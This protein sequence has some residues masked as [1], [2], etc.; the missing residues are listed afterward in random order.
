VSH[1]QRAF[2]TLHVKSIADDGDQRVITG[3]VSTPETDRQGDRMEPAGAKFRLPM[4][5]LWQHD[6]SQPIG[7]VFAAKVRPDGIHI[8]ARLPRILE[9]GRLKDRVDEAWQSIKH[10]LVRGLSIGWNPIDMVPLKGGRFHVKTWEWWEASAVTIP[11]NQSATILAVKSAAVASL[12][13]SGTDRSLSPGVS[14]SPRATSMNISEQIES[15]Q[16]DLQVKSARLEELETKDANEGGLEETE[17]SERDTLAEEIEAASKR[18]KRMKALE[19][20]Q[21]VQARTVVASTPTQTPKSAGRVEVVNPDLPKGTLFTRYAMAVAAGKGSLS[22]TLAYAKRWDRQTPQVSAFIKA[23]AGTSVVQSPG[24]GGELVNPNTMATE[25]IDLLRPKTII[26]RVPGFNKVP[27][28]IPL[29]EQTGGST[30][31]WV[32]EGGSKPIGELAFTRTTFGYNKVAGIIVLTDEL[33]RLSTP[34]AEEKV[35]EDLVKACAKFLDEA[36][37][38]VAKT[39]VAGVNP[40]SI[41]NGV[42]SPA[43]S[44]STLAD[45]QY[46]LNLALANFDESTENLVIV[47]TPALARG[48]SMLTNPLGQAP[49]GFNV[50]PMGG[51]LLGYPVI[52]SGSVDAGTIVI[53]A[54]GEIYL[55]DDERVTLDASN[56]ATLD[57]DGGSPHTATFNL[58]QNNCVGIRAERWITWQ[59]RRATGAVAVIDTASYGPAVGS[60]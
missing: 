52:V 48:I 38:Q 9:S 36:F 5:F 4:A 46:D 7:E 49:Q 10:G 19:G 53:F 22:D 47:T 13:A 6:Q 51:T 27:F 50:T 32:G 25:F 14:G 30:F 8:S 44:G 18:I 34:S 54:P 45:L 58:W 37:I 39:A 33:V 29:I 23:E 16:A 59:K 41:T 24:W 21:A 56:Q 15:A 28:N 2:S 12:A 26:G 11:A 17:T 35:R 31:A 20:A 42:T 3:V 55:A 57:M 60:P 1:L 40:A 43:A